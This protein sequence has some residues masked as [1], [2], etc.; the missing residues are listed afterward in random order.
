MSICCGKTALNGNSAYTE[1]ARLRRLVIDSDCD[2]GRVRGANVTVCCDLKLKKSEVTGDTTEF[3]LPPSLQLQKSLACYTG[4]G[5]GLLSAAD[6]R[7]I[8][9]EK[10]KGAIGTETALL[11]RRIDTVTTCASLSTSP[12]ERFATYAGPVI[13]PGCPPLPPPLLYPENYPLPCPPPPG[14]RGY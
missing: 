9:R 11:Q 1:A 10:L 3:T 14:N 7:R 12:T 6:A 5:I 8:A 2:K 4:N 13:P